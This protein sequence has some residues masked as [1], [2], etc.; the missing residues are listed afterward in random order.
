MSTWTELAT[1]MLA[2]DGPAA[3]VCRQ[4]LMPAEGHDAVIFPP[5]FAAAEG[6]GRAGYNIDSLDPNDPKAPRIAI[7]DTVGSQANRMEPLFKGA[8]GDSTPYSRL[9]PQIEVKAGNKIINLLDAGHRAADAIVRYSMLG[10]KLREAF[11]TYQGS[12]DATLLAKIAPTSLVF[13]AW[14]SRDTQTKLPRLVA[15][16]IRAYDVVELTRSAQYNPPVD[17]VGLG[18]IEDAD[19]K[20]VLDAASEL[21]FRHAP[22]GGTH[23]GVIVRGEIRR[24]AILSLAGLRAVGPKGASGEELRRYILGLA[25][26]AMTFDREHHL[27]QGCLLVG[28][29]DRPPIWELVAHDGTRK[30]VAPSGD[31]ALSF[32]QDAANSFGVG[33]SRTVEFDVKAANEALREKAGGKGRGKKGG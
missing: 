24:E 1:Q 32:A 31:A 33:E 14:D 18:L 15:S 12:G 20:K 10:S 3:L 25:L 8:N 7:I 21:G 4:W 22:A 9:V 6:G 5:T 13:G 16:T 23:G 27:R 17:Y 19:D 2:F 11:D 28:D 26:V 30:P 29:P